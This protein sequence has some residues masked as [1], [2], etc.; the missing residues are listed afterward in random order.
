MSSPHPVLVV[1]PR[2]Q[3]LA[4][5]GMLLEK[6]ERT[7]REA[8][9]AQYRRVAEELTALLSDAK[10]DPALERIL[11]AFPA[12]AELYEN[13]RYRHA[14]LCR[15]PLDESL[16]SEQQAVSLIERLRRPH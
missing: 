9:P 8:S 4:S 16:S 5:L 13:L 14:G 3:L 1:P 7:P 15:S 2:L 10:P 12:T 11:E 6:L